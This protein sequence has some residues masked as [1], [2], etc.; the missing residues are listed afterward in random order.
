M[1]SL[2]TYKFNV[3]L[4]CVN[5]IEHIHNNVKIESRIKNNDITEKM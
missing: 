4:R 3:I 5:V 1:S 2:T